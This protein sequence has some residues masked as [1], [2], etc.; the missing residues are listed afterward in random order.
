M[1][2]DDP[3]EP[4]QD[5]KASA[6]SRITKKINSRSASHHFN[7][8]AAADANEIVSRNNNHH[9]NENARNALE[10]SSPSK[11]QGSRQTHTSVV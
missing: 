4:I 1:I 5:E 6:S 7:L 2:D 11:K 3:I 8:N 9:V 10:L